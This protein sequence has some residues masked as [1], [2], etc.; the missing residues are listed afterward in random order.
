MTKF[1]IEGLILAAGRS[2]RFHQLELSFSKCLL[3]LKDSNILNYIISGMVKARIYQINIVAN[4]YTIDLQKEQLS[5]AN[6]RKFGIDPDNLEINL[7]ENNFPERENGYSLYLGL[8]N[9][10][11]EYLLMSMADHVFSKNIFNRLKKKYRGQDILLATDPMKIKGYYDLDD[12]TKVRGFKF[13]IQEIGKTIPNYNRIDMGA[14]IIK[15]STILK[16]CEKLESSRY[17]FGVSDVVKNAIISELRAE[18][19]DFS[20]VIWVDIDDS[21]IYNNV[22]E[23]FS[24]ASELYP[25]GVNP[26]ENRQYI[27]NEN[28]YGD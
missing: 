17:K 6:L 14:F 21:N 1:E 11:A 16:E 3:P 7:I 26:D 12:A 22:L 20:N 8:L 4:G 28:L 24:P 9:S 15:K 10:R 18:Y 25:F 5:R 23:L 19:L 13:T 27:I 2:S